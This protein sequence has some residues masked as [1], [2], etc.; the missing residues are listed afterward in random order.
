MS[1]IDYKGNNENLIVRSLA[2][3][4][5]SSR[6]TS[7]TYHDDE[8]TRFNYQTENGKRLLSKVTDIDGYNLNY[9]YTTV[10]TGK[11][12]RVASVTE[13]DGDAVGGS[14][15]IQYGHNQ[16]TFT[17]QSGNKQIAQFNNWGNTISIQ[18]DL[19]RAQYGQYASD[20]PGDGGKG[21]QL[22]LS[23]KLQNTVG[24]RMAAGNF[25]NS[26]TWSTSSDNISFQFISGTAYSG[27][28]SLKATTTADAV[29]PNVY[30]PSYTVANGKTVTFS[31]YVKTGAAP[32]YLTITDGTKTLRSETLDKNSD[33]TRLQ[34]SYTNKS[35]DEK[36]I[37]CRL[38]VKGQGVTYMD[39]VQLE[40]A[41]VAS[42]FNLVANGDFRYTGYWN[43]TSRYTLGASYAAPAPELNT[44]VH[45]VTGSPSSTNRIYQTINVS[46]AKGD[47]YVLAGWAKG[48]SVPLEPL[49]GHSSDIREFGIIA[50]FNNTDESKTTVKLNFN[51]CVSSWQYA[52]QAIV[53][54][55][56][57]DSIKIELAYD[58]N[59]NTVY[60]DGIQ[61]FK[62]QF[63]QSYTYDEDGN[64]ISV[65]DLQKQKTT[66]EYTDN[67]L[68]KEILPTGAELTYTY[69]DYHNVKTATTET[70]VKY[71]FTY[72]TYGNNTSVSVV[73]G[74]KK[75]TS[76]ATYT[77]DANRIATITDSAG[78][79]T[80]YS[81]AKNSNNL[82]WVQYPEDTEATRT[83][84]TYDEW[85]RLLVGVTADTSSGETLQANYTYTDDQLKKITT[86]STTYNFA[87]GDFAQTS[88]IKVGTQTLAT[89]TYTDET[90]Y[91]K[92][93]AYGNG[94]SVSYT[95]DK[96]GRVTKQTYED[97]EKVEYLYDNDGNLTTVVDSESGITSY[98]SSDFVGRSAQY[99]EVGDDYEASLTYN[100][101][102]NNQL[103]KITELIGDA[104][105]NI[106]ITYDDDNRVATWRKY[107]SKVN[108]TYDAYGR[109]SN[110]KTEHINTNTDTNTEILTETYTYYSPGTNLSSTQVSKYKTTSNGNYDVTYTYTY[111]DNGNILSVSDGTNKTTYVYDSANQLLR[112][113]NQAAG[114]TTVWTYDDAGNILTR[115]EYAYTTGTVGT[116]TDTVTYTYGNS[117]WGDQLTSYD[118]QTITYDQIGNPLTDGT[119]TYTWKHGRELASMTKGS[120][121]W[122]YTYNADGLR[123]KRTDGTD[124]Y[125]Y[126]YLDGQLVQLTVDDSDEEILMKFSYD[127]DGVPLSVTYEGTTYYYVTNLQ[128][129]VV[130]IVNQSGNVRVAYSYDAW[131]N[132]LSTTGGAANTIGKYNPLRYR[133]YVYDEGTGLYYVSSRYYDPE[134]GRF[135]NADGIGLLG[136]NGDFAS[137]NL[138]AYC[139]NNPVAREDKSGE[140]WNV[141]AGAVVGGTI[142]LVTSIV[143]E[144]IEGDFT[145][146]DVGQIAISTTIGAMEGAMIAFC[147]AAS[148]AISA[149]AS[150]ADTALNGWIDGDSVGDIVINSLVSG[151]IGAV[152]GSGGS[153][154]VKGGKLLNEAVDSLG[155]VS[156]KGVN[157]IVKQT[158]QKTIHKV[159]LNVSQAYIS[160]QVEDFAYASVYAFSSYYARTVANGYSLG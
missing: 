6:L 51:D 160:G 147:P 37:R 53:A 113:N 28:K 4:Y 11:P 80:T 20:E 16:T 100:Y 99:R 46:G 56:A 2:F 30:S 155:K 109:V 152:S 126:I 86:G 19:G 26:P 21:N 36:S 63:G 129:D 146:K 7:V 101:N 125:D 57:Y 90:N 136:A 67:D 156:S 138:F 150:V 151:T 110:M 137:Y 135:I 39:C 35:G 18:D 55:K 58:Y 15:T 108:Y 73:N 153:E 107:Y 24:N 47:C 93:L 127:A 10:A 92:K 98:T 77:S 124:T 149:V 23:S 85:Y 159:K 128:G 44:V 102:V 14:L 48:Y 97:G 69:D 94:D 29:N 60:F 76:S 95:Y 154:F 148:M 43:E 114:T 91:L 89:Y 145:L 50:T 5:T 122:E 141:V 143:S 49:D 144:V 139:G 13:R 123:T 119:W 41:A 142:S 157:P 118:G 111:D 65:V 62:E 9:T 133:G 75:I 71:E 1:A 96:H 25:D 78:N 22:T 45:K 88:S 42:R 68:T 116:A 3:A 40:D 38:V 17:D 121:T 32:S 105:R 112:E 106:F 74:T 140:L 134:I 131:G 130:G 54:K 27:N 120:T 132:V 158:A 117:N 33:W 8:V 70:G 61:L 83:E 59:C 79:V 87:Y 64:V 72:D 34:V 12:T 104:K 81:Y 52:S 31:A 66:Y 115:K 82:N 103:T 84:Y